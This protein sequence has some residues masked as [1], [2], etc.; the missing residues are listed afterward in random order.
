MI[1]RY[2]MYTE[3]TCGFLLSAARRQLLRDR[4]GYPFCADPSL[5]PLT[6]NLNTS[7][8]DGV[9]SS[10]YS[11]YVLEVR[12]NDDDGENLPLRVGLDPTTEGES[13]ETILVAEKSTCSLSFLN[14]QSWS[15]LNVTY[16]MFD[17]QTP[18]HEDGDTLSLLT[19][20]MAS[21]QQTNL[22]SMVLVANG[23][24]GAVPTELGRLIA[25]GNMHLVGNKPTGML[26]TELGSLRALTQLNMFLNQLNGTI[27]TELGSLTALLL[28]QNDLTGAIPTELGRLTALQQLSVFDNKLDGTIPT[29]L[30]RLTALGALLLDQ[31]CLTGAIPTELDRLTA[32]QEL[33]VHKNNLDG[34]IPTE[35]GS[36]TV[37]TTLCIGRNDL[38]TGAIPTELG[39]LTA[40]KLLTAHINERPQWYHTNRIWQLDGLGLALSVQQ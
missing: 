3:C 19:W 32:L 13:Y 24:K 30:G 12:C 39:G 1:A 34:T 23:L 18:K 10:L 2:K 15:A 9:D 31:N 22:A 11:A 7:I 38:I 20:P 37:V 6:I 29:E 16:Q 40:L 4:I 28:D 21:L 25:L 8:G 27:P 17:S 26:P 36:L 14:I 35:C 5:V 33:T